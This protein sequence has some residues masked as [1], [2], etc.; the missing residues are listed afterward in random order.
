MSRHGGPLVR[1]GRLRARLAALAAFAALVTA[2]GVGSASPAA[3]L[4]SCSGGEYSGADGLYHCYEI[5]VFGPRFGGAAYPLNEIAADLHAPCLKVGD[6]NNSELNFELW[7]D[8][9]DN[10][11]AGT[12]VEEGLQAGV[13]E[14]LPAGWHWFWADNRPN[15]G[16][17]HGH[18]ISGGTTT[19]T[20]VYFKW[21]GNGNWNVY[22]AGSYIGESTFNG[23]WAEGGQ[24]GAE[25]TTNT[26]ALQARAY[27][28]E[29]ADP[30][31][32]WHPA[33][34]SLFDAYHGPLYGGLS[35]DGSTPGY[36]GMMAWGGNCSS[37][38]T[39]IAAPA[40]KPLSA[41]AAPSAL[42]AI[43]L[44]QAQM[45]GEPNPGSISF[46]STTRAQA[47]KILNTATTGDDAV[48]VIKMTGHFTA[49]NA[50]LAAK[51]RVPTGTTM[52][53]TVSAATGQVTDWGITDSAPDLSPA[54]HATAL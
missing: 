51:G 4:T 20:Q 9:N 2:T 14:G 1:T 53:V 50:G 41:A 34:E 44:S 23:D 27:N 52:T 48:Y 26:L 18:Y 54:G 17:Y 36:S 19:D 21:L 31:W 29:Y 22:R 40:A 47:D 42:R 3:A 32:T 13:S 46:V 28:F 6:V 7:M 16:G 12:W 25:S 8:T 35:S 43:A 10:I 11:G 33:P 15:G 24:V 39:T 45:S 5:A 30:N 37:A 38:T 49:K